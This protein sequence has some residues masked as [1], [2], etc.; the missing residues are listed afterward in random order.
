MSTKHTPGP[1][2]VKHSE[3]KAAWNVVGTKLGGKY[4]IARCPY[5]IHTPVDKNNLD[6]LSHESEEAKANA[7]LIAAA[8]E[9][10]EAMQEFIDRVDKGEVRSTRTYNK[11]KE[12]INKA[13]I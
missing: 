10:L 11:F 7:K 9:M 4:K 12:I 6:L 8:P 13:T 3:S 5:V 1:W 2:Q